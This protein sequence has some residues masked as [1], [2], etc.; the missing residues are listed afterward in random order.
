MKK[1][2]AI[3]RTSKFDAVRDALADV[4]VRFFT[5]MEVR[6]YGLQ[7]GEKH[8]YR[9]A[10]L[11]AEYISRLQMEIVVTNEK[12]EEVLDTIEKAGRTGSTGDG[13]IFVYDVVKSVRIRSSERDKDVI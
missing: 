3:I 11:G 10:D 4:G 2:E 6:G 5:L 9:G 1:I 8:M 12:V 7:K 13:K